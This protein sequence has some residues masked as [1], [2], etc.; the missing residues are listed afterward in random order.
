MYSEV[1]VMQ[2]P[3]VTETSRL[4]AHRRQVA[5]VRWSLVAAPPEP[6]PTGLAQHRDPLRGIE[7]GHPRNTRFPTDW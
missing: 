6:D 1:E 5:L 4:S 7:R 2:A 3:K